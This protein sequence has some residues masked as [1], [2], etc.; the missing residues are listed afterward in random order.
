MNDFE[1]AISAAQSVLVSAAT[2]A[3]LDSSVTALQNAM[4]AFRDARQEGSK[5]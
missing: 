4:T 3:E 2:Q 5:T 1:T